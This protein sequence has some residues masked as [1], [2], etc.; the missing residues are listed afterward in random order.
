MSFPSL[1]L[2]P[3]IDLYPGE[4]IVSAGPTPSLPHFDTTNGFQFGADGKPV[5][6]EQDSTTDVESCIINILE[7]PL[8]GYL[9]DATFGADVGLFTG[10]PLDP[11]QIVNAIDEWEP[12]AQGI[13]I[14]DLSTIL[15]QQRG[16]AV[17]LV[18][19][20]TGPEG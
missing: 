1:D 8:G 13:T 15:D 3:D 19:A 7:C 17:I 11:T 18:Q 2:F 4:P 14:Q 6:C 20:E 12:R 16:E 10:L 9:A 5:V